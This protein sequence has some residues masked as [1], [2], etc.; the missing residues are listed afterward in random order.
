MTDSLYDVS[1]II[2]IDL[3]NI[4]RSILEGSSNKLLDVKHILEKKQINSF[5]R[6]FTIKK[7]K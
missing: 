2:N 7:N 4:L 3:Y 5:S 1:M 6:K